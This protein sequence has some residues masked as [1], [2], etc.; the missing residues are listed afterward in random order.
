ME[1]NVPQQAKFCADIYTTVHAWFELQVVAEFEESPVH[2][3][4]GR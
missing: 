1:E 3:S 4:G 2:D